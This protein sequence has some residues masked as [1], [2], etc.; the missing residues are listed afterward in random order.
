MHN[1]TGSLDAQAN[2]EEWADGSFSTLAILTTHLS[3]IGGLT[4][5]TGLLQTYAVVVLA[6]TTRPICF[7][8]DLG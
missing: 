4:L 5:L 2:L 6:G 7:Y 8:S 3:S 1:S